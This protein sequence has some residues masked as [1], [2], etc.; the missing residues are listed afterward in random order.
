[1][2]GWLR[3]RKRSSLAPDP[4]KLAPGEVIQFSQ[5]DVTERH[6][7]DTH[8]GPE[9]WIA[10]SPLNRIMPDPV[11]MGLPEPDADAETVYRIAQR[12]SRFRE[13]IG[14]P[15]DGVYCPLCHIANT[16]R[17]RL[18]TACPRCGRPLLAFGWD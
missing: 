15:Q 6:D 8:L 4:T 11:P 17:R 14:I 18:G 12:M 1:M 7:D 2:L 16:Q 13:A 3:R 5:V 10:T 9:D